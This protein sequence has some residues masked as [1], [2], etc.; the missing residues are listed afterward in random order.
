M[1]LS[2]KYDIWKLKISNEHQYTQK[3][4]IGCGGKKNSR[5]MTG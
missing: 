5:R 2:L 1:K 4:K 3:C